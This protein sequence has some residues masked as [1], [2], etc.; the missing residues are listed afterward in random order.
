MNFLILH[1]MGPSWRWLASVADVELALPRYAPEHEYLIHNAYVPFPDFAKDIC[2]D[3]IVLNSSFINI[4]HTREGMERLRK[5]YGFIKDA[6]AFKV[7]LPQ[8]DYW[9][10]E[11]RDEWFTEW[12]INRI[13]PVCSKEHWNILYPK[14]IAAKRQ[15]VLGYTGYITPR[16]R[17]IT[18]HPKLRR[19]RQFDVVYR[20]KGRPGYPNRIGILKSEIGEK[21]KDSFAN[22]KLNLN[23]STRQE[24]IILGEQW[25]EFVENSRCILGSNSGSSLLVKNHSMAERIQKYMY[26]NPQAEISEVEAACFP[27]EDGK[28]SFTAI[29]PRNLEAGLLKTVQILIPGPYSNI[30]SPWEHYVPL[31]EDC[32]NKYELMKIIKDL[33]AQEE[34]ATRCKERLLTFEDIQV[35]NFV[36]KL[37]DAISSSLRANHLSL[38]P[39]LFL[40]EV[41][42]HREIVSQL[43]RLTDKFLLHQEKMLKVKR[44]IRSMLPLQVLAFLRRLRSK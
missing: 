11:V 1:N 14:Y 35:E 17:M 3:A 42:R 16:L 12:N 15:M 13:Y 20:A 31:A 21:F 26:E 4:S 29:S 39:D 23:I 43:E 7:A 30:L 37:I 5:E 27:G 41:K 6:S 10:S 18:K 8:D 2:F 9:C 24:D 28:Y 44:S 22:Q 25:L 19:L 32:S 40:R 34:I 36:T 38:P 33:S